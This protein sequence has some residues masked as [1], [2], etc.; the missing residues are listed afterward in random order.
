V[1]SFLESLWSRMT[2]FGGRSLT[3]G[4][5]SVS[6]TVIVSDVVFVKVTEVVCAVIISGFPA[7]LART[8]HEMSKYLGRIGM[9]RIMQCALR[10]TRCDRVQS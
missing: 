6:R 2:G 9:K 8:Y 1:R 5:V 4:V 3:T 10:E 7:M